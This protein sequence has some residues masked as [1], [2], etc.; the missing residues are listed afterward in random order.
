MRDLI[1]GN[2]K[3]KHIF[4]DLDHTLWDFEGNS[5]ETL[6]RLY[7]DFKLE[8]C[9]I[10]CFETFRIC[11]EGHNERLWERFRKGHIKR[12]ELRWKRM[13]HT[14][15]DFKYT[16]LALTQ[17]LSAT[18]LDILPKQGKLMPYA[19][20]VLDY[21]VAGDYRVH[22]ITNGFEATQWQ[23]MRTSGIDA[24]FGQVIT[25]EN[26]KSMKP[27][28]EIFEYAL[29]AAGAS[30][31]ESIMIGDALEADVLG[32]QA[33]GIDQVYFNVWKKPHAEHPTYEI[34]CLSKLKGII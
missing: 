11:Y 5:R 1:N 26:S 28:K 25:S 27:Q 12:E 2:M 18:Y 21:C 7:D 16:D 24:Y 29:K 33:A 10:N 8:A 23:K 22:I 31:E 19:K 14:L 3:Y 6:R 15:L 13:W 9:G 32:A 30:R 34:D 20:E 17:S 4:F